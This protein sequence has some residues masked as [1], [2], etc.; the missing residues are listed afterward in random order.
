MASQQLFDAIPFYAGLTLDAIGG[1]GVRWPVTE[2]AAALGA[3]PWEPVQ[4][5][6]PPA[7][8]G[9]V[10]RR[11]AARHLALA[12]G[13]A[14]GRPLAGPALHAAAPG[15]RALA[16]R[17]RPARRPRRRRGGGRRQRHARARRRAAARL[18]AGRVGVPRRGHARPARE[19]AD[20]PG[21]RGAPRRRRGR[22]GARH[23]RDRD[24]RRRG[25]RRGAA[26]RRAGHPADAARRATGARHDRP[27]RR[28][29]LRGLV[30][31]APQGAG[32]LRRGLPVRADRAA[33]RAQDPRPLPAPLRAEPRRPVRRA[34]ADGRHREAAV[35][36]AVPPQ[37]LDRLDVRARARDLDV[38]RGGGARDRPV[39][40]HRRHLRHAGR[41]L[42]DRSEHRDPLRVRVRRHRL[43]R[44]DARRL[45]VG[46]QVRVPRLDARRRAADLLRDRAGPRARRPDR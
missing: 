24:T 10:R 17:R 33:R 37:R 44:A 12:V 42:R 29:L 30:D 28:R 25:P 32:H 5:E 40:E 35:Q 7:G 43:L 3:T 16:G 46:R 11:A 41:A 13:G 22:A 34:A 2:A 14:R 45:G 23:R 38:H 9:G 15:R 20:R 36:G 8:R 21:R 6:V 19:P 27:R 26:E 18:G 31:P 4:L 39:L 1:R